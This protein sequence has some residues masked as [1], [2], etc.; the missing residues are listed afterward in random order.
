M[1]GVKVECTEAR[2]TPQ[3]MLA[4]LDRIQVL[5]KLTAGGQP[6]LFGWD[7]QTL[8]LMLL[9]ER[10]DGPPLVMEISAE[11]VVQNLLTAYDTL[12]GGEE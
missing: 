5:A 12:V 8:M 6:A 11:N 10:G 3:E 4:M 7:P 1:D 2:T 9:L